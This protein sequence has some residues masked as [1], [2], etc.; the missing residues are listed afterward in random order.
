MDIIIYGISGDLA[1]RKLIPAITSLLEKGKI[2]ADTRVVGFSRSP[3]HFEGP[4]EYQHIQGSYGDPEAF[5]KLS[6]VLR[7]HVKQLFYL[8][9]PPETSREVITTIH[10]TGLNP[11]L[12]LI[13]KPFGIGYEDA[14]DFAHYIET[15]FQPGQCL[16]VDHYAGKKELREI[17]KED[18]ANIQEIECEMFETATVEHRK[19]FYNEVGELRDVGQNH[20]LFML[21][22]VLK[23]EGKR[24]DILSALMPDATSDFYFGRYEGNEGRE[25]MF[26]IFAKID[27][28][29]FD[30]IK[31]ILRAGKGVNKNRAAINI[32]YRSGKDKEII[33]SSSP[34]AY[35]HILE[36]ALSGNADQFLSDEEVLSNWKFIENVE[37]IKKEAPLHSYPVG[38]DVSILL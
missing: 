25:T 20:L 7:P 38:S 23:G 24:E 11:T 10:N 15:H 27:K 30:H 19:G 5:N 37:K 14:K 16:K 32:K 26:S 8:A 33:L 22:S 28:P 35:A 36:N 18:P 4:F 12:I 2:P 21:A 1:G 13:E 34:E 29:G 31:I 6:E 17:E 3:K 9:L